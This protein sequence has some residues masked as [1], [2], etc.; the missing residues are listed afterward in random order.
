MQSFIRLVVTDKTYYFKKCWAVLTS[1]ILM[2][3]H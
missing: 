3:P 2:Y 1:Q